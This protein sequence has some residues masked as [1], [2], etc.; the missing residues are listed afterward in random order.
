MGARLILETSLI[1]KTRPILETRLILETNSGDEAY[2]GDEAELA[3]EANIN[4]ADG[5]DSF[6]PVLSIFAFGLGVDLDR[7]P[8]PNRKSEPDA[9]QDK[10]NRPGPAMACSF[11]I[12]IQGKST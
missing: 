11:P 9:T 3:D 4:A 7:P 2:S 12:Y 5:R 6:P 1:L 10:G 8:T